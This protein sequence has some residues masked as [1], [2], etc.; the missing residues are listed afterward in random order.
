LKTPAEPDAVLSLDEAA[1]LLD[2]LNAPPVGAAGSLDISPTDE[3]IDALL[4]DMPADKAAPRPSPGGHSSRPGTTASV[5]P[6]SQL[7]DLSADL[8]E[9]LRQKLETVRQALSTD[10][11]EALAL[12]DHLDELRQA[13]QAEAARVAEFNRA[14][15]A[16]RE[17][18]EYLLE[19]QK[20]AEA[21]RSRHEA[22]QSRI[23][24]LRRSWP[25]SAPV[26]M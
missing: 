25:N 6:P 24:T 3:E 8:A 9:G 14:A 10:L 2:S 20:A 18:E 15:E 12:L 22:A 5:D 17:A 4:K 13:T 1:E 11:D 19:A 16:A 7:P 26:T 23:A 21:A